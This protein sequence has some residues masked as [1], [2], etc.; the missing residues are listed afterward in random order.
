MVLLDNE[1]CTEIKDQP[2]LGK[3][4]SVAGSEIVP[5]ITALRNDTCGIGSGSRNVGLILVIAC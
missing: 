1:T 3:L 4:C 2:V 5:V